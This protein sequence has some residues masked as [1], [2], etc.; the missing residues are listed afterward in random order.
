MVNDS[1]DFGK[2]PI[3]RIVSVAG[4]RIQRCRPTW[5]CSV[6]KPSQLKD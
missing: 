3:P 1:V 6:R 2:D 5:G 4:S